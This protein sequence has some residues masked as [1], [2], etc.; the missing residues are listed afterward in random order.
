MRKR[1]EK[2]EGEETNNDN[3]QYIHTH[4]ELGFEKID[5]HPIVMNNEVNQLVSITE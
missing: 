5:L 3:I 4:A 2:K 1:Y